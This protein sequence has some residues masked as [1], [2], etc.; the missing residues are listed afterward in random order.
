MGNSGKKLKA[1]VLYADLDAS[2]ALVE[3]FTS[4][5]A[6]EVYKAFL[7][8]AS[9]VVRSE[10]GEIRSFDGDRVMG[11][12]MSDSKNTSAARA[13]LKINYAV[14]SIVNP[15]LSKRYPSTSYS[16]RHTVGVD[17]SEMLAVRVG[18]RDR[19]DITWVGRAANYAAKM[20]ALSSEF[21]CYITSDV[22]SSMNGSVKFGGRP[23]RAM[24]EPV[25]W[26]G[27]QIYRSNW[28]WRV[29]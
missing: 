12:F 24:W 18:F 16:V 26:D 2:T 29:D 23:E 11:I 7:Y 22:Y 8:C 28:A 17:T 15:V 4:E 3:K 20:N 10:G 27:R 13:A 21:G 5:F 1:T 25:N 19:N 9:R 14:R 6:A